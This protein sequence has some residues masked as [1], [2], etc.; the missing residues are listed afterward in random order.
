MVKVT[1]TDFEHL[2]GV[3]N[4]IGVQNIYYILSEHIYDG[5]L[6]VICFYDK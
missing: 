1:R 5:T 4:T 2:E 6:F 3:I